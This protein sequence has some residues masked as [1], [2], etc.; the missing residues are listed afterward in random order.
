MDLAI[1]IAIQVTASTRSFMHCANL[2][3]PLDS[4]HSRFAAELNAEEGVMLGISLFF[5]SLKDRVMEWHGGL[6]GRD[7]FFKECLQ[8]TAKKGLASRTL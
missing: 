6:G 7:G 2:E 3:F 8:Q 1:N 5:F 4:F